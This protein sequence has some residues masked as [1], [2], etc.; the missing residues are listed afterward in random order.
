MQKYNRDKR[1]TYNARIKNINA[2]DTYNAHD[3]RTRIHINV[4]YDG[5]NHTQY[6]KIIYG[7]TRD[8]RAQTYVNTT[9]AINDIFPD[10]NAPHN[11]HTHRA[12]APYHKFIPQPHNHISYNRHTQRIPRYLRGEDKDTIHKD[13]RTVKCIIMNYD[14]EIVYIGMMRRTRTVNATQGTIDI[15]LHR[16]KR[17]MQAHERA[18][19]PDRIIHSMT[20]R[21]IKAH[22]VEIYYI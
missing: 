9:N 10:I 12:N 2:H 19:D 5:Y 16:N 15:T 7:K 6:V 22:D 8:T 14:E 21:E 3:K 11:A 1:A 13:T 20:V 17:T 4:H 18:I